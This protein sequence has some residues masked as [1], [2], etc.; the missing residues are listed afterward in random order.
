MVPVQLP[1]VTWVEITYA[2]A[3][4]LVSAQNSSARMMAD[5]MDSNFCEGMFVFVGDLLSVS[6][7][8]HLTSFWPRW[9][10]KFAF[11]YPDLL[12][13]ILSYTFCV[14]MTLALL[15]SMPVSTLLSISLIPFDQICGID[16]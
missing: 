3:D 14:S 9:K 11:F 12:E 5:A 10:F 7:S 2:S 4:C 15:N 16:L 13:N 8:V 6:Q 1:G